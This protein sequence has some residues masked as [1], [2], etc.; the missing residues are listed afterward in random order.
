M[1]DLNIKT[2]VKIADDTIATIAGIAATSIEGVASL[3]EGLTFKGL[4]FIG[5]KSLKQGIVITKDEKDNSLSVKVTIVIK[6]GYDLKKTCYN[7]QEKVKESIESML[8][9]SVKEVVVKVAKVDDV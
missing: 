7:I 6:Q 2:N 5:S 1:A 4:Q 3:G 8:D 9:M